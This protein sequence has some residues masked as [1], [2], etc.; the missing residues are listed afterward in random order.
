MLD[1]VLRVATLNLWGEQGPVAARWPLVEAGLAALDADVILLQE[2]RQLEGRLENQ[3]A[4]LARRLG[5]S[6]TF[7]PTV[8]WGGGDEGLAIVS[9]LPLS[10][11]HHVELPHATADERRIVLGATLATPDGP[12][13]VFSTHLNYRM[14]DGQKREDQL[15]AAEAVVARHP[16][17]VKIWG[18]DFNCTSDSDE[19]RWLR[20]LRSID[21][22]RV[23]YQDAYALAHPGEAGVTW[24]SRNTHTAP[25][26]WLEPERRIDF[27]FVSHRNRDG[28][29][30][31]LSADVVLDAAD[32][33]GTF[34]SDHF[35]V[36]AD[37]RIRP[38][39]TL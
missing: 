22:R 38:T 31:I 26:D 36:R 5:M 1:G 4:A 21:G 13:G 16:A 2:V 19:L 12:V 27:V 18:G 3:A 34:P 20:G 30:A 35:A 17:R 6:H 14:A 32:T 29:G 9:R 24:S 33:Q 25:L 7:A 37:V 15:V 11:A 23:Y 39:R 8:T 10:D 28:S